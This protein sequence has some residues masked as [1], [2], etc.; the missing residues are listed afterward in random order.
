MDLHVYIKVGQILL[1]QHYM[2]L[3]WRIPVIGLARSRLCLF[4]FRR[5][6]GK[7]QEKEAMKEEMYL[8]GFKAQTSFWGKSDL[9][10]P[11]PHIHRQHVAFLDIVA[12]PGSLLTSGSGRWGFPSRLG[13]PHREMNHCS[14]RPTKQS[15]LPCR[16]WR[17]QGRK[18]QFT[19]VRCIQKQMPATRYRNGGKCAV[20]GCVSSGQTKPG[21]CCL[22][23]FQFPTMSAPASSPGPPALPHRR[24]GR[25]RARPAALP[26]AKVPGEGD[27]GLRTE[28]KRRPPGAQFMFLKNSLY[29]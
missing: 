23:P 15:W 18:I 19:G 27:P 25:L 8:P 21:K 1:T 20:E 28:A 26:G 9:V 11:L 24:P 17:Q 29:C 22:S 6:H 2:K 7:Q 10:E 16:F 3:Q 12:I 4:G 5:D 13:F 14:L